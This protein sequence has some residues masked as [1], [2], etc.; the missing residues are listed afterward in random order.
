MQA[1]LVLSVWCI[2]WHMLCLLLLI[3][4]ASCTI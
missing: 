1:R 2:F 3:T 4:S